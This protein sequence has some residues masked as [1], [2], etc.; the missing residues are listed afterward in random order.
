MN[1]IIT[2]VMLALAMA[3]AGSAHAEFKWKHPGADPYATSRDEAMKTRENAFLKLGFPTEVVA[4]FMEATKKP[5]E[6][7]KLAMGDRLT[8]MLSKGAVVHKDVVISWKSPIRGTELVAPAEKWQVTWEGKT[9][10][11]ILFEVCYNWSSIIGSVP[12]SIEPPVKQ[13]TLPPSTGIIAT[14]PNVYFLKVNFWERA[15]LKL[16]GVEQT[17]AKEELGQKQFAGVPHVSKTHG[18]QFRK[19]Y[20]AGALK[21]SSTQHK[22]RVSLIM[23]PESSGGAQDIT[24]EEVLGDINVTGLYELQFTRAQLDKWDA[25]RVVA[26]NGDAISPP[27]FNKT[28]VHEL[29]F[30]NH[31]SG[32]RLGEWDSNP[33]PDCIMNEH[34]IE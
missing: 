33:D 26:I 24:A 17:H 20:A 4:R 12:K 2:A 27:R 14:C 15:A 9:Y 7:V 13:Y 19:A 25:I 11:A 22:L 28:G 32:T 3:L 34:W 5:G 21:W 8:T 6:E 10:T 18:G 1:K 31:I 16:P 23:T 29:R 30:F